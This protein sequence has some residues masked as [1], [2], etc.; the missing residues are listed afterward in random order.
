[1]QTCL[2]MAHAGRI[3]GI[4]QHET[5]DP[6]HEYEKFSLAGKPHA[7]LRDLHAQVH[8]AERV[9][10]AHRIRGPHSDGYAR[11]ACGTH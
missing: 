9:G 10:P 1:M 4:L 6:F 11:A 3:S 7:P 8:K 5:P 2:G